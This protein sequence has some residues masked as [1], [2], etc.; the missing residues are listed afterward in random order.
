[1]RTEKNLVKSETNKTDYYENKTV[2][3]NSLFKRK[4]KHYN[5][6]NKKSG[7]PNFRYKN[8]DDKR[9]AIYGSLD[10]NDLKKALKLSPH[11]L[12]PSKITTTNTQSPLKVI[13]NTPNKT[14]FTRMA[15]V[16]IKKAG[17]ESVFY[18]FQKKETPNFYVSPTKS[19]RSLDEISIRLSSPSSDKKIIPEVLVTPEII[20]KARENPRQP[21]KWAFNTVSA[22]EMVMLY[23]QDAEG[24][25]FELSHLLRHQHGGY[26]FEKNKEEFSKILTLVPEGHNSNRL[27]VVEEPGSKIIK[28]CRRALFYS[29]K[30]E[31]IKKNDQPTHLGG[32]ETSIW[33][34]GESKITI[35]LDSQNTQVP[36]KA[37]ADM[38]NNIYHY[39]FANKPENDITSPAICDLKMSRS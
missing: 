29:A 39:V 21:T 35:I 37:L 28:K 34:D 38:M 19:A 3:S 8:S 31:L 13:S 26:N 17:E 6:E 2:N 12:S 30:S 7:N 14:E 23:E 9:I 11:Y 24:I 15:K 25:R 32:K 20:E 16:I 33:H 1:M 27:A 4:R 5:Y 36:S 22:R 10:N 18:I